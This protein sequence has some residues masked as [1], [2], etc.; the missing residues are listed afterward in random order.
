MFVSYADCHDNNHE[1]KDFCNNS[2]AQLWATLPFIRCLASEPV[3]C[4]ALS[5]TPWVSLLLSIG[6]GHTV[7]ID[8]DSKLTKSLESSNNSDNSVTETR[9]NI[10]QASDANEKCED[11]TVTDST[12]KEEDVVLI[13]QNDENCDEKMPS[14]GSGDFN[15]AVNDSLSTSAKFE[16]RSRAATASHPQ[17]HS[18][19]EDYNHVEASA[20]CFANDSAFKN[21]KNNSVNYM[22]KN[23]YDNSEQVL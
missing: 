4:S 22:G 23:F 18:D 9:S 12:A 10:T 6:T 17:L 2:L 8:I 21:Q 15:Q 16:L 1:K 20:E 11:T 3:M 19:C 13:L 7:S 5:A 14:L